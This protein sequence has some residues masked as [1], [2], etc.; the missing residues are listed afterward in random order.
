MP[1]QV[2][3]T[4][5]CFEYGLAV[6]RT[7]YIPRHM[8][9][10]GTSFLSVYGS[11]VPHMTLPLSTPSQSQLNLLQ[12]CSWFLLKKNETVTLLG[13]G[14]GFRMLVLAV[15]V[16]WEL[17]SD[18]TS[19]EMQ[20]RGPLGSSGCEH[21]HRWCIFIQTQWGWINPFYI[22][23]PLIMLTFLLQLL[24][25]STWMHVNHGRIKW[26]KGP[27]VDCILRRKQNRSRKG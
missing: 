17:L 11:E 27:I 26:W 7:E 15:L 12:A 18:E 4:R 19:C 5:N 13:C 9:V 22:E 20:V 21:V 25:W 8:Q 6:H 1:W 3:V 14:H 10:T 2:S 16:Q 23:L 24:A